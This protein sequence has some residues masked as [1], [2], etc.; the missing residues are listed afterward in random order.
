MEA[1]VAARVAAMLDKVP[2]PEEAPP[3]ESP[4]EEVATAEAVSAALA[5]PVPVVKFSPVVSQSLGS[6]RRRRKAVR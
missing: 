5:L 1:M 6:R 3:E 4:V 2:P